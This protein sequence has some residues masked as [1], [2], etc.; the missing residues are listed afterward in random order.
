MVLRLMSLRNFTDGIGYAVLSSVSIHRVVASRVKIPRVEVTGWAVCRILNL[1]FLPPYS[2]HSSILLPSPSSPLMESHRYA[3]LSSSDSQLPQYNKHHEATGHGRS[4]E[5]RV[6]LWG[7]CLPTRRVS[8][9]A[10]LTIVVFGF[11]AVSHVVYIRAFPPPPPPK[12]GEFDACPHLLIPNPTRYR[13][14][15]TNTEDK[16]DWAKMM[17]PSELMDLIDLGLA[18]PKRLI[19]QSWKTRDNLPDHFQKWSD[20]WRRIHG[21]NWTYVLWT[22]EDNKQLVQRYYIDYFDVYNDLPREI[23]RADMVRNMY[24]HKFGG[25]YGDLDL[26]PLSPL[27]KHITDFATDTLTAPV[28]YVGRM[29]DNDEFEHSIPNAFM[30]STSPGHPF[31]LTPLAFVR[32]HQKEEIYNQEP[33]SLT[34]PVAL[35]SCVKTWQEKDH[36]APIKVLEDGKIYPLNWANSSKRN[37]CLCRMHS[38]W[39]NDEQCNA[40]F[41]NSWTITY[42]THSWA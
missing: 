12:E 35:R 15:P 8:R 23:Y 5:R 21:S 22:D 33:E 17:R 41:P 38:P 26:V 39:F 30:A 29:G 9:W 34:G 7:A 40:Q 4:I 18:P 37:W 1:I 28:A 24:M 3:P 16:S 31:W 32:D 14:A 27:Q 2:I 42:W 19:H 25:V 6:C 13:V 11:L 10:L 20:D 36:K